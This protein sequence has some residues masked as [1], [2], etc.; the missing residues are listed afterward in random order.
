[1]DTVKDLRPD[2]GIESDGRDFLAASEGL[3]LSP[4]E[5]S[6]HWAGRAREWMRAHPLDVVRLAGAKLILLWNMREQFQIESADMYRNRAGPLG[7]PFLGTFLFVAVVGLVGAVHAGAWPAV[8]PALRAYLI[9][10]TAGMLPFFV[11]DR[12]RVHLVPALVML[13]AMAVHAW[14]HRPARSGG[15]A[16]FALPAA[17]AAALALVPITQP[18][19]RLQDMMEAMDMGTRWLDAGQPDL[20]LTEYD[21]ALA[22][23]TTLAG[24]EEMIGPDPRAGLYFNYGYALRAT[25]RA[26]E[27]LPWIRRAVETVPTN[28]KFVRTLADAYLVRGRTREGDSLLTLVEQLAGADGEALLSRGYAAAREGRH[29]QAESLFAAAVSR[30]MRH[31][32]A[33]GALIR[34]QVQQRALDRA[35]ATVER[36]KRTGAAPHVLRLYEAFVLAA[37]GERE[38]AA[39]L[40]AGMPETIGFDP[41]LGRVRA[42]TEEMIRAGGPAAADDAGPAAETPAP[43]AAGAHLVDRGYDAASDGRFA[44]AESLFAAAVRANAHDGTAWGALI[45]VQVQRRALERA[46][47]SVDR[48]RQAGAP[49]AVARLYDAFV[50]AAAG[51]GARA[52]AALADVPEAVT[53][54]DPTLGWVRSTTEKMIAAGGG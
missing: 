31:M 1:V 8:G 30:G 33:W 44:E 43:G 7:I 18:S 46:R 20:A 42:A 48:Y 52:R 50:L 24:V 21:R 37:G 27:A 23:D 32:A 35:R 39:T 4:Q 26:E 47:A 2:G 13:G 49:A 28:P 6:S 16:R 15:L 29:A 11:T 5:S 54:S 25:G 17:L 9:V 45:R 14:R 41:I 36:F 51:E 40:M 19:A 34:I 53:R 12:Y 22:I 38:R 3:S 10:F